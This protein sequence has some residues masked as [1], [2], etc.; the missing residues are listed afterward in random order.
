MNKVL[1]YLKPGFRVGNYV[2]K[3]RLGSGW[4]AEAYLVEE[5]PT[6]A[7]RV[8]KL[9][10]LHDDAQ[11]I[12]NLRD[13]EHYCWV[14]EQLS[15]IGLL[16]RYYHMGHVFLKSGEGIGN[17]YMIQEFIQGKPFRVKDCTSSM[18]SSLQSQVA[19]THKLGFALGD[20][21]KENLLLQKGSIRMV[22]CTY[23]RHDKP[24]DRIAADLKAFNSLFG[25]HIKA[26]AGASSASGA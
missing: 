18:I 3:R 2:V 13:F 10:E 5:V 9:Y 16:P 25:K 15:D 7:K 21:S 24:N 4:T 6:Q 17:Y 20:W 23:G 11:Q 14:V 1:F 26:E 19:R 8:L 12:K 22:D